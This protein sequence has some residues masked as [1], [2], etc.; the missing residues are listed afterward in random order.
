VDRVGFLPVEADQAVLGEHVVVVAQHWTR[1]LYGRRAKRLTVVLRVAELFHDLHKIRPADY[2]D[3]HALARLE[4]K[5]A[6]TIS[7]LLNW[8]ASRETGSA[9][10]RGRVRV[11]STSKSRTVRDIF[12]REGSDYAGTNVGWETRG[13]SLE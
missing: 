4:E 1:P 7:D 10:W 5:C 2:R 3:R 13:Y 6:H 12:M 8:E 9:T 11:P